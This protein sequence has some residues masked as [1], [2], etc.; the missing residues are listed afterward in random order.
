ML[1][2]RGPSLF[3]ALIVAIAA[4]PAVA[5]VLDDV[6]SEVLDAPASDDGD[7][8]DD[9]HH[10]GSHDYDDDHRARGDHGHS[11][12]YDDDDDDSILGDLLGTFLVYSVLPHGGEFARYPYADDVTG[13]Y[14]DERAAVF[15]SRVF[16][17][18]IGFEYGDDFDSLRRYSGDG[19]FELGGW[20]GVD[21]Q[22]D[23]YREQLPGGSDNLTIGDVNFL[24][25]LFDTPCTSWRW[26]IGANFLNDAAGNDSGL[27]L[28]MRMQAFPIRPLVLSGEADAGWL[29]NASTVHGSLSLGVIHKHAEVYA[30]YDYRKIGTV[31]LEG[32]MFGVRWWY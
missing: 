17:G 11:H 28:T 25:H 8:D 22:W 5:G 10:R 24:F 3:V 4:A 20:F 1:V 13:Y 7:D 26:G 9:H 19:L 30:G 18:H 14:L 2:L 23:H 21:T 32:P 6:R 29:G 15:P 12:C 27:N 31:E 16:S